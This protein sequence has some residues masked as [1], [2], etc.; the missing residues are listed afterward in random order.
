MGKLSPT[1]EDRAVSVAEGVLDAPGA[2]RPVRVNGRTN[3]SVSGVFTGTLQ[4]ERSFDGGDTWIAITA[5]GAPIEFTGP[6]SEEIEEAEAGMLY[7][8]NAV[9]LSAGAANWRFSR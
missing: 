5:A 9:A 4:L 7:R 1:A 3:V 2:S 6:F 8:L